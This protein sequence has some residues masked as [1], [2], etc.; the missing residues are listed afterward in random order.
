VAASV[1]LTKSGE[2]RNPSTVAG[3]FGVTVAMR[4]TRLFVPDD[5]SDYFDWASGTKIPKAGV[6]YQY[7]IELGTTSTVISPAP[8]AGGRFGSQ[9]ALNDLHFCTDEKTVDTPQGDG[10]VVYIFDQQ[11][12][13]HIATIGPPALPRPQQPGLAC[14]ESLLFLCYGGYKDGADNAFYWGGTIQ[15]VSLD[16]VSPLYGS[17]IRTIDAPIDATGPIT[18]RACSA[19]GDLLVVSFIRYADAKGGPELSEEG[20]LLFD[21]RFLHLSSVPYRLISQATGSETLASANHS[22]AKAHPRLITSKRIFY[23]KVP[24]GFKFAGEQI[25]IY[26]FKNFDEYDVG[27]KPI[28]VA[29]PSTYEAGFGNFVVELDAVILVSTPF[30]AQ[31]TGSKSYGEIYAIDKASFTAAFGP[32]MTSIL[33]GDKA[34]PGVGVFAATSSH[35]AVGLASGM[36]GG[37][38][39][40]YTIEA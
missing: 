11:T 2:F 4:D 37:V 12:L 19:H 6:V 16:P 22:L 38:V 29:S 20:L 40:I 21:L 18:I 7:D 34:R 32:A 3:R 33:S 5:A 1:S 30:E 28:E 15:A 31:W 26:P 10:G 14:N 27:T 36:F 17:V 8:V 24:F 39:E 25:K 13:T 23:E 9:I 35:L